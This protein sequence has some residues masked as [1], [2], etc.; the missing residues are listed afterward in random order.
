[1]LRGG[2]IWPGSNQGAWINGSCLQ[3]SGRQ[4]DLRVQE[5]E[6]CT[7]LCCGTIHPHGQC[8]TEQI[9]R[10]GKKKVCVHKLRTSFASFIF[11]CVCVCVYLYLCALL[12]MC[13]AVGRHS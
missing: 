5:G 13:V 10:G 8:S 9:C 4:S 2:I 1:M 11:L 12:C 3:L 6:W 7:A